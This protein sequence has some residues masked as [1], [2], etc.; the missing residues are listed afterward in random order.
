[1]TGFFSGL[2]P[3]K[4]GRPVVLDASRPEQALPHLLLDPQPDGTWVC[5][6]KLINPDGTT[7]FNAQA[8]DLTEIVPFFRSWVTDPELC[9]R[10][11]F[12]IDIPE[13]PS[14]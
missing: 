10:R 9:L 12:F 11:V 1:M 2:R 7:D 5:Y 3:K 14:K 13:E 8:F 6:I 4:D